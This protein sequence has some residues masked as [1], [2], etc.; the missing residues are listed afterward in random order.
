MNDLTGNDLRDA[1]IAFAAVDAA[2]T[3]DSGLMHV[4]A[5]I[6]LPTVALFGPTDPQLWAPLNPLAAV[7]EPPSDRPCPRCHRPD[8]ND[9]HHRDVD[10]ITVERVFDAVVTTLASRR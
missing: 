2:V 10:E 6:G 5:A 1:I 4:A 8:C 3:N 7:I 9:V